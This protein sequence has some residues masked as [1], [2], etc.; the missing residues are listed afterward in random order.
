MIGQQRRE[1][2][3]KQTEA[4]RLKKLETIGNQETNSWARIEVLIEQK[5]ERGYNQAVRI[6]R[7][8]RDLVVHQKRK[9]VRITAAIES[10]WAG[11]SG[12]AFSTFLDIQMALWDNSAVKFRPSH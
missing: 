5:H 12:E 11:L 4:E 8:L 6:L 9:A 7:D 2:E 1:V 10:G 3:R